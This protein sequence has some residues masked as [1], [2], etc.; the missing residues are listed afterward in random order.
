MT[1]AVQACLARGSQCVNRCNIYDLWVGLST[2]LSP[3]ET[4]PGCGVLT[5]CSFLLPVALLVWTADSVSS[6]AP[7][8]GHLGC[9]W[10]GAVMKKVA[11][12]IRP[13]CLF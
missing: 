13:H 5:V 9:L 2:Q 6:R 4:H 8:E 10:V 1:H 12:N 11:V 3:L 7:A